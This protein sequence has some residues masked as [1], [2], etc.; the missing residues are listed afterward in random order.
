MGSLLGDVGCQCDLNVPVK[1]I[2]INFVRSRVSYC[3]YMQKTSGCCCCNA[4]EE[5][6]KERDSFFLRANSQMIEGQHE[7][8]KVQSTPFT[9][10]QPFE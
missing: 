8:F 4:R 3:S 1:K 6:P 10:A 7:I 9:V 5:V 2:Y